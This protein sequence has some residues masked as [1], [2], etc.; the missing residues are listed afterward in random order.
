[1]KKTNLLHSDLSYLLATLGHTDQIVIADAGLP[2]SDAT[3]RIDLALTHGVPSFIQTV[4]VILSEA[5]IE[6][7][8]LAQ[9]LVDQNPAVHSQLMSLLQTER[10]QS[11]KNIPVSYV[12]HSEFKEKTHV[13]KG[14]VRTG[15][16]TPFA[17]V[18]FKMGVTF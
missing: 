9:E 12:P 15:E 3:N 8:V 4:K 1:M 5:Q 16:C 14:V 7:V 18:I 17:N 2:I 10:S 11:G 13:S 6:E